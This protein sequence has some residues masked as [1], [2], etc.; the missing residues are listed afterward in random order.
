MFILTSE[1]SQSTDIAEETDRR[2]SALHEEL[3]RANAV[4]E[5][6]SQ[7]LEELDQ[8]M[9]AERDK[10]IAV[11]EKELQRQHDLQSDLEVMQKELYEREMK[12]TALTE[13]LQKEQKMHQELQATVQALE[14]SL[15]EQQSVGLEKELLQ[16]TMHEKEKNIDALE[17][18]VL[19]LEREKQ[20]VS[21]KNLRYEAEIK[22]M[23]S[24]TEDLN[25]RL[26][27]ATRIG[28]ETDREKAQLQEKFDS[29]NKEKANLKE[30]LEEAE[31][32][33]EGM[34]V[35][36]K[37]LKDQSNTQVQFVAIGII[38]LVCIIIY[39]KV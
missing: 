24:T 6:L 13:D 4:N 11:L 23:I 38:I 2:N 17:E 37:R 9:S 5:K 32:H 29:L 34:K 18:K 25:S 3:S 15:H 21:S 14:Q 10:S 28:Q 20:S 39:I 35:E 1:L 36:V 22:E 8:N 19:A 33:L 12:V 31:Q 7:E 30:T 27:E 26:L 16:H